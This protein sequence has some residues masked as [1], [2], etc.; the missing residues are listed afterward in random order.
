MTGFLR[1]AAAILTLLLA[2]IAAAATESV[3]SFSADLTVDATNTLTVVEKI[4]VHSEGNKI[5][6]GITRAIP[7]TVIDATG[8]AVPVKISNIVVARDGYADGVEITE[9]KDAVNIRIGKPDVK[10]GNGDHIYTISYTVTGAIT[11]DAAARRLAWFVTGYDW[12]LPI[13]NSAA[14][15]YLPAGSGSATVAASAGARG[16]DT[17][18]A[19]ISEASPGRIVAAMPKPLEPGQGLAVAVTWAAAP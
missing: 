13:E 7:A 3:L 17:G 19:T 6:R 5:V 1:A 12:T 10:L 2:P 18:Q 11:G 4:G 8:K 9:G 14:R 16:A 15:I